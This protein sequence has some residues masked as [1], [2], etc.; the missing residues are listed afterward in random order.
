VWER[1]VRHDLRGAAHTRPTAVRRV[2]NIP[3]TANAPPSTSVDSSGRMEFLE[4]LLDRAVSAIP[5][6]L[7]EHVVIFGSAPIVF[8]GLKP[9][10]TFDL[11]LFIGENTCRALVALGF[12]EDTDE[13]GLPRIMVAE[14]VKVVSVWPG[15]KFAEVFAASAPQDGSRGLRVA[16]LQLQ[17]AS[18]ALL[19][20]GYG[21][22]RQNHRCSFFA[23]ELS[24][25]WRVEPSED[26]RTNT[27]KSVTVA[28]SPP[29]RPHH[30]LDEH[31][32]I[33]PRRPGGRRSL[34]RHRHGNYPP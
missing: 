25:C 21:H 15:V 22:P 23:R 24:D 8:A 29:R 18:A 2:S 9:D 7:H 1:A 6:H 10:V 30:A 32:E 31:R 26:G 12:E 16:A 11:D 33:H 20:G 34:N 19:V 28:Q 13:R 3:R 17:G 14:A 4:R 5:T 27:F